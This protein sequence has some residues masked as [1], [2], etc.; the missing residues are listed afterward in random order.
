M[1]SIIWEGKILNRLETTHSKTYTYIN[2]DISTFSHP[3]KE[4]I[5]TGK[6]YRS[7]KIKYA[8]SGSTTSANFD[9]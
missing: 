4:V 7:D 3:V 1:P 8:V 6:P 5:W 2:I 9:G